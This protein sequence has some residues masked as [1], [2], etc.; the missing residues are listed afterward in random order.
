MP[1][2]LGDHKMVD[3]RFEKVIDLLTEIRDLLQ[4]ACELNQAQSM[5]ALLRAIPDGGEDEAEPAE[6]Q[7]TAA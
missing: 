6:P 4:A 7:K 1:M 2:D 5:A 3:D